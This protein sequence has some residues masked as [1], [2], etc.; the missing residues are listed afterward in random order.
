[1]MPSAIAVPT[2]AQP[3]TDINDEPESSV[4]NERE[5]PQEKITDPFDPEQIKIRT[6]NIVV[7]QLVSRIGYE[8]IDLAP[9]FQRLRGIWNTERKSRLIESLLLRIPIPVFYVAADESEIWSVVDGVQRMS[10]IDDYVTGKFV[11]ERLQYLTRL[12]G[13]GHDALPRPLQRRISETQLIVNVIEPGTPAEVKFNVFLRINT[14]GMTLNGQEIRHALHPGPARDYLKELAQSDQFT[15]A[16][17]GSIK[18]IR[19]ADRE[20]VLRFLAFHIEP[21]EKYT[22]NGLDDY[23]GNIME[24]I[25]RMSVDERDVITV[26]FKKA[27]RAAFDIFGENAFRKPPGENNRRR[28]VN[29]ALFETWSVQLARCSPEQIAILVER[30][31]D[32]QHR[33]TRLMTED[34]DFEGAVSLSTGTTRRVQKR[35]QA[36]KQLVEEFV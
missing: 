21:W 14:G 17:N 23:L 5:D 27:M 35:F 26:D 15:K 3:A 25:N 24:K 12:D 32:V 9:D 19:M 28:P 1:M 6:V 30:R 4:E 33:F 18:E 10:T 34:G 22:T 20:C 2:S 11:L 13:L 16:T 7:G 8:E 31:E 29:R 36:I